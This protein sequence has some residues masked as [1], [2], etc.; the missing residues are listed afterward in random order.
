MASR[1]FLITYV[2]YIILLLNSAD[3]EVRSG[4]DL[5]FL[6]RLF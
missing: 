5:I 6:A 1:K 4:S 3:L 2:I